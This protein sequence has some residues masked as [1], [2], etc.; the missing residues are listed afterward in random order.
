MEWIQQSLYLNAGTENLI[1][2]E[3]SIYLRERGCSME[4]HDRE[5]KIKDLKKSG[6]LN[7]LLNRNRDKAKKLIN[8][9]EKVEN[10]LENLEEKLSKIPRVGKYLKDVPVFISLV[11]AYITKE[12]TDVPFR[13][14]VAIVSA[15]IYVLNGFDFIPDFIPVVGLLDDA[16]VT[17]FAYKMVHKD[18]EKYRAW[19]KEKK[20]VDEKV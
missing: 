14:V 1:D 11:R 3:K 20:I 9:K 2:S 18:V 7:R 17:A 8:D 13:S 15:L 6:K 19:R 10:M 12:Y 4:K 16:A 5:N